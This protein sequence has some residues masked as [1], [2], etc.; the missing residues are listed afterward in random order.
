MGTFFPLTPPCAI[1]WQNAFN[2]TQI[3]QLITEDSD[4]IGKQWSLHIKDI[5]TPASPLRKG[6]KV[7]IDE[8]VAALNVGEGAFVTNVFPT[9]AGV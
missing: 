4:L 9:A 2:N 1:L 3:H 6:Y 7:N 5:I 8:R